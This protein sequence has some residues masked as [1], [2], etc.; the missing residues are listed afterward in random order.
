MDKRE[1]VLVLSNIRSLHNVGSLFRSADAFGVSKIYLC[2]LTGTPDS[3][4]GEKISKTALGAEKYITWVY[5]KRTADAIRELR[6]NGFQIVAL[7]LAKN[8][9]KLPKVKFKNKVALV[10]GHEV[11][12]VTKSI[13]NMADLVAEI[14]MQGKKESLNV[15]VAGGIALFAIRN[16]Q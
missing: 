6:K 8:S 9:I 1:I 2:G 14:P 11:T 7:E 16:V 3:L 10:V 12:G 13:L 15:S 5:K 4:H